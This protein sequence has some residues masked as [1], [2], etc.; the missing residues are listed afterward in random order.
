MNAAMIV[1]TH[2]FA[3]TAKSVHR[4]NYAVLALHVFINILCTLDIDKSVHTI[5][6]L[7]SQKHVLMRHLLNFKFI[8]LDHLKLSI[9]VPSISK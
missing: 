8:L 2:S 1:N 7:F 5:L 9:I 3:F 6:I 4:Y